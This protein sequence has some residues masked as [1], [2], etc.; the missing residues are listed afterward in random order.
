MLKR[1]SCCIC[2]WPVQLERCARSLSQTTGVCN[3]R[4]QP[5]SRHFYPGRPNRIESRTPIC[6]PWRNGLFL[7]LAAQRASPYPEDLSQYVTA[8][9]LIFQHAAE[10]AK[11]RKAVLIKKYLVAIRSRRAF[12]A[13]SKLAF[14]QAAKV[15]ISRAEIDSIFFGAI[16]LQPQLPFDRILFVRT[17][18]IVRL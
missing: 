17:I 10:V 18:N 12:I 7:P 4:V 16:S 3:R 15:A 13:T 8:S 11:L 9:K 1:P 2:Q 14:Y 5:T 6:S